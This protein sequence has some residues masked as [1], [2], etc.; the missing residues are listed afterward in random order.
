MIHVGANTSVHGKSVTGTSFASHPRGRQE[1][2]DAPISPLRRHRAEV[3]P[4]TSSPVSIF[5]GKKY[6]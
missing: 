5:S 3:T 2:L 6:N 1:L 4:V